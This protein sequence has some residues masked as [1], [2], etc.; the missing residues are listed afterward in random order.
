MPPHPP[1]KRPPLTHF[2]CLPL[3]GPKAVPQWQASLRKFEDDVTGMSESAIAQD[4]SA[5]G[6]ASAPTSTSTSTSTPST[7]TPNKENGKGKAKG[8]GIPVKA[9][10]PLGTLHLTIGVMSLEEEGKLER[11][12]EL[13]KGLDLGA[14]LRDAEKRE[15]V[16]TTLTSTTLPI[17]PIPPSQPNQNA[18]SLP[19]TLSF[20]GLHSMHS[21][22]STS[23]LY[24]PPT[25][26]TGRLFPFCQSLRDR[27]ATEGFMV[28]E[29]RALKLHATVLNT[30]YAD[31]VSPSKKLV[32]GA[33]G[34]FGVVKTDVGAVEERLEEEYQEHDQEAGEEA[35]EEELESRSSKP[36]GKGRSKGKKKIVK[37]DAR[38]LMERYRE[39]EWVRDVRIEKVAVC[40]MGAKKVIDGKGVVVGE[41][42]TEVA[43]VSMP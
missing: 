24:T 14:L 36:R 42:Y 8:S 3:T 35:R 26:S 4:T 20:T 22:K 37:F 43:S 11:A 32:Q 41:E 27:F 30:I 39:F 7:T 9:I 19:L 17:S 2:L 29:E 5:A 16:D 6:P 21:P 1:K 38:G 34:R 28:D 40:E 23:F 33:D 25:D 31:K 18:S 12:V 10:R 15:G 13:L